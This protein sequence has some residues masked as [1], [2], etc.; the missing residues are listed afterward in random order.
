MMRP[1]IAAGALTLALA[2][3]SFVG[4]LPGMDRIADLV[5]PGSEAPR[6]NPV[7][8]SGSQPVPAPLLG[9]GVGD[10]PLAVVAGQP[11]WIVD[12][13][14]KCATSNPFARAD[15]EIRWFGTCED[16]RLTG[17]GTL[18][19]YIEGIESE[20]NEG[21]FR[22]GEFDGEVI[23]TYPDGEVIV[24]SYADGIRDGAFTIIGVAGSHVRANY[25][26]GDLLDESE[27]TVAEVQSWQNERASAYPGVV[28]AQAASQSPQVSASSPSANRQVI[29]DAP[30]ASRDTIALLAAQPAPAQQVPV[31]Q[32]ARAD[33]GDTLQRAPVAVS[34]TRAM[35]SEIAVATAASEPNQSA[36]AQRTAHVTQ[37][38]GGRMQLAA[39][40]VD[41]PPA[42]RLPV[43]TAAAPVSVAT[44]PER[45]FAATGT[46]LIAGDGRPTQLEVARTGGAEPVALTAP[47]L[48]GALRIE[49]DDSGSLAQRYAGRDGPWVIGANAAR[50]SGVQPLVVRAPVA[51]VAVT[52]APPVAASGASPV[53]DADAMFAAAYQLELQGSYAAAERQYHDLLVTY[54]SAPAAL[55]ANARLESL[56]GSRGTVQVAQNQSAIAPVPQEQYVVSA[57][58]PSPRYSGLPPAGT[59]GNPALALESVLIN[60]TVCSQNGLYANDARWC[61]LV[62]FDEGQFMRVEVT[63]ITINGFGQIGITRS[64]CTGNTFL[65]WFSRGT[66]IRVPKRCMQVVG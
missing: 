42:P 57:N 22:A 2:G 59:V 49:R 62:T 26:M 36:Y 39:L 17:R 18:V 28:L 32:L 40:Q 29:A 15:E 53:R 5:T 46:M 45:S 35:R 38:L 34:P 65:T 31:V 63:D 41:P 44:T 54:P 30:A 12:P 55:L 25:R 43:V 6:L 51:E 21:T 60:K 7:A 11:G 10:G 64:T 66:S 58:S 50:Q 9:A 1:L 16:G 61:G 8:S 4:G 19:W 48:T 14:S 24:G 27:M 47:R 33:V 37:A 3:C 13:V 23:T 56:A 20:R 52:P